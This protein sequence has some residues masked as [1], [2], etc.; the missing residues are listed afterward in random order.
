MPGII[1]P[2]VK[3]LLEKLD[4]IDETLME[5]AVWLKRIVYFLEAREE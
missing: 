4:S 5:I 1:D 3:A 2:R